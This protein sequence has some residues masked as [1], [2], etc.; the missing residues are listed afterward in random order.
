MGCTGRPSRCHERGSTVV[1]FA[2]VFPLL[3]VVTLGVVDVGRLIVSRVLLTHAASHGVR[4]ASLSSTTSDTTVTTAIR[5]A[6]PM[7]GTGISVGTVGCIRPPWPPG[8]TTCTLANKAR[9]DRVSVTATYT[10]S[11]SF[12]SSFART[13][14]QTSWVVV[15]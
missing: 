2:V 15:P 11:P 12:F 6:A 8:T 1:E 9:G 4:V 14:T 13:L 10:F 3:C 7:L 5:D